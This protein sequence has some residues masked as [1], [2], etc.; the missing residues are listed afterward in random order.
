MSECWLLT[1]D[2]SFPSS[3]TLCHFGW[4]DSF[5]RKKKK[6]KERRIPALI[7][8]KSTGIAFRKFRYCELV[9]P[10][11][12]HWLVILKFD[13]AAPLSFLLPFPFYIS[14]LNVLLWEKA[15]ISQV[16]S[17]LANK[18]LPHLSEET[19]LH[20]LEVYQN[21]SSLNQIVAKMLLWPENSV[22][23]WVDQL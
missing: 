21:N 17:S 7:F 6:E 22:L 16:T 5:W 3:A 11:F 15:Y 9:H 23:P 1:A 12:Q 18:F 2:V 14:K 10:C 20:Y 19:I 4:Y 13:S 8:I